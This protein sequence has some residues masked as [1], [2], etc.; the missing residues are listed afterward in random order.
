VID[1]TSSTRSLLNIAKLEAKEFFDDSLPEYATL[2]HTWGEEEVSH[3]GLKNGNY[4]HIEGYA[5]R[6]G[7]CLIASS[8]NIGWV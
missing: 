3:Q 5:K 2:S 6:R 1:I 7:C 8:S 4:A